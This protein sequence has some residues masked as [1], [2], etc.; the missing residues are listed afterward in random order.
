ME[1]MVYK[2]VFPVL[3]TPFTDSGDVD[4]ESMRNLVRFELDSK[5]DGL[6]ILGI[7]LSLIHI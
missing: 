4:I 3:V 5:V 1:K 7:T 2:G 6:T